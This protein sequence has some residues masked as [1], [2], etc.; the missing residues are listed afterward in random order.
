M[1]I[2]YK[3]SA[4]AAALGVT[5]VLLFI[6]EPSVFTY[7]KG[8]VLGF[9]MDMNFVILGSLILLERIIPYTKTKLFR[10][11]IL[12]DYVAY[13]LIQEGVISVFIIS[14]LT[15]FVKSYHLFNI[16]KQPFALQVF[17]LLLIEDFCGYW[18]HRW[19]HKSFYWR[20]HEVHHSS[21]DVDWLSGVRNHIIESAAPVT[22]NAFAFFLFFGDIRIAEIAGALVTF[23][24]IYEHAN[25][26]HKLGWLQ[27]ILVSAEMHRCHH[28]R[29]VR[30]QSTN[31][32]LIFSVWDW[33]FGTGY[34][35]KEE[36]Y[37][38]IPF[39]TDPDYPQNYIQAHIYAHK[40][41]MGPRKIFTA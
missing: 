36:D 9:V 38:G 10:T 19:A 12:S 27:Y 11:G 22:I 32:G 25:I 16:T 3:V 21:T 5:G 26:K 13:N 29:D 20:I 17:I 18:Y 34:Y 33:I 4:I 37:K 31:Y 6:Y 7:M 41:K 23:H 14:A 8:G 30:F 39:G 15:H 2:F 40:K 24:G 1:K 28:M 35:P